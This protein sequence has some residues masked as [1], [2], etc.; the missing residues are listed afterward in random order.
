MKRKAIT[1]G[2]LF[3]LFALLREYILGSLRA[4]QREGHR[5][6]GEEWKQS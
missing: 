2:A 4:A 5:Q 3:G 6:S 1:I